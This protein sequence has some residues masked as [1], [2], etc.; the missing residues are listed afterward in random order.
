MD[1]DREMVFR[2]GGRQVVEHRFDH[3][4]REFLGGQP[5]T[6][7]DDLRH[8]LEVAPAVDQSLIKRGHAVL[9]Q[10]LAGCARFLGAIQ[11]GDGLDRRRDGREEGLRI[12]RP[13]EAHFQHAHFFAL[14]DEV[15]DGFVRRFAAR[16]HQHNNAFGIGGAFV[17]EVG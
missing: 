15:L 2:L 3:R 14:F 10:W 9:V 13:I 1:A 8:G 4:R 11:H 5:V 16:A 17:L 7:A 6:A 12:E